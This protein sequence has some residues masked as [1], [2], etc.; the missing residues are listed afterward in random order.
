MITKEIDITKLK[1][2]DWKW[3]VGFTIAVAIALMLYSAAQWLANK[4]KA[5][6]PTKQIEE[7]II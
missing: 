6:I 7:E 1:P 5:V 4:T 3:L 2:F